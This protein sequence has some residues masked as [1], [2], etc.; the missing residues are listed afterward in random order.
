MAKSFLLKHNTGVT[1]IEIMVSVF[2]FVLI[3]F[4]VSAFQKDIFTFYTNLSNSLNAQQEARRAFKTMTAEIRSASPSSLGSYTIY[5]ASPTSLTF[6]GE[7]DED[8]FKERIRYFLDGNILKK[9]ILK[10]SGSPLT[11]NPANEIITEMIHSVS[12][13]GMP[14]FEYHNADYDGTTNPLEN[15]VNTQEVRLVKVTIMIDLDTNRPPP[16]I[17]MMTQV[18]LRNLKDNL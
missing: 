14:I 10:P 1:L 13:G 7:I 18:S 5:Q 6:Y 11:Y 15:P 16:P 17:T 2:I 12:N 9:G 8:Q 4:A 3:G